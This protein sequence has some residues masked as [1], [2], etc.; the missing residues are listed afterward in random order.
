MVTAPLCHFIKANSEYMVVLEPKARQVQIQID[1]SLKCAVLGQCR[2]KPSIEGLLLHCAT[3]H[4]EQLSQEN[5]VPRQVMR[6]EVMQVEVTMHH[7]LK[8]G[9]R[10][11]SHEEDSVL[12][13]ILSLREVAL[14]HQPLRRPVAAGAATLENDCAVPHGSGEVL[15]VPFTCVGME[16]LRGR[17]QISFM[18][19]FD[20]Q[21][22]Y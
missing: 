15:K 13:G 10:C 16:N 12:G 19:S 20:S 22:D 21:G 14:E 6:G 9:G 7:V 8:A 18:Q 2:I 5:A 1:T 4:L 17:V 11:G 3:S